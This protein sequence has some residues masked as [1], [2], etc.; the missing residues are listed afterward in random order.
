MW[1]V[2]VASE[3]AVFFWE[4]GRRA[5]RER[6]RARRAWRVAA[7]VAAVFRESRVVDLGARKRR[8]VVWRVDKGRS[9]SVEGVSMPFLRVGGRFSRRALLLALRGGVLVWGCEGGMKGGWA[10]YQSYS[11]NSRPRAWTRWAKVSW[12]SKVHVWLCCS[13]GNLMVISTARESVDEG[14]SSLAW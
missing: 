5:R 10:S 4:G 7:S 11:G 8:V 2:K 1:N 6:A 14:S 12:D 3:R 13:G 9:G